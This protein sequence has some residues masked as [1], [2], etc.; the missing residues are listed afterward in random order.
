MKTSH[1][2][3]TLMLQE[4]KPLP[5]LPKKNRFLLTPATK[6][7]CPLYA[8]CFLPWI[9]PSMVYTLWGTECACIACTCRPAVDFGFSP[10]NVLSHKLQESQ[11]VWKKHQHFSC[12]WQTIHSALKPLV[13]PST[14]QSWPLCVI[15]AKRI[16]ERASPVSSLRCW[17]T[18]L[19]LSGHWCW[20]SPEYEDQ[21]QSLQCS[22]C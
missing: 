12:W 7:C 13:L 5:L 6:S 8:R 16:R 1:P 3:Y 15:V 22:Q 10:D 17:N 20:K 4:D 2:S 11:R 18:G 19:V 21:V 14:I 9:L